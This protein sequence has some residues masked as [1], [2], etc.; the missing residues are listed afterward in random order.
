MRGR[1]RASH[2]AAIDLQAN[3]SLLHA[4]VAAELLYLEARGSLFY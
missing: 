4:H 3:H 1:A 2:K